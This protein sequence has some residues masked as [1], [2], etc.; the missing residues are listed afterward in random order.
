M[1]HI[2]NYKYIVCAFNQKLIILLMFSIPI[3]HYDHFALLDFDL[4]MR[5]M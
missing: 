3:L 4:Q 1:I 5:T 2:F